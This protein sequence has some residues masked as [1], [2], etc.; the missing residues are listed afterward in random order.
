MKKMLTFGALFVSAYISFMLLTLPAQWVVR[1]SPQIKALAPLKFDGIDGTIWQGKIAHLQ[2][3]NE[4]IS[5]L[6]WDFDGWSLLRLAPQMAIRFGD[7]QG[8]NGQGT[9]GWQGSLFAKQV[10]VNL[11]AQW[12]L[13]KWPPPLPIPLTLSG[14]WQLKISEFRQGQLGCDALNGQLDW[15]DAN[16]DTPAGKLALG[17]PRVTLQCQASLLQA[18]W[19]QQSDAV[20][21]EGK[22]TV[23]ADGQYLFQGHLKP[24]S[25][26]PA[27]MQQALPLLGQPD[28]QGRYPLRYQGRW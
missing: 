26:L 7:R 23:K 17:E 13:Q 2:Y 4:T 1:F 12:A 16:V 15:Y 10:T 24:S 27:Q 8:L 20:N 5:Q 6:R 9:I 11:P 25:E 3:Q 19:V 28:N 14:H 21:S 18:D 22:L